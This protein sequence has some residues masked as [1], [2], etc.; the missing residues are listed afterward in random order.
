MVWRP[1]GKVWI[2]YLSHHTTVGVKQSPSPPHTH[3]PHILRKVMFLVSLTYMLEWWVGFFECLFVVFFWVWFLVFEFIFICLGVL[4]FC[5]GGVFHTL[6][7]I[8]IHLSQT[9]LILSPPTTVS[10]LFC[11]LFCWC[12]LGILLLF[13]VVVLC[14]ECYG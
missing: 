12:F 8:H 13:F 2:Y 6:V 14:S 1:K 4:V 9:N 7:Q 10:F 11:C 5:V 3:V